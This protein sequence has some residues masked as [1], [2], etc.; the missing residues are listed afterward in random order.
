MSSLNLSKDLL[1]LKKKHKLKLLVAVTEDYDYQDFVSCNMA[2]QIASNS[3][4]ILKSI[5]DDAQYERRA[6]HI[7]KLASVKEAKKQNYLG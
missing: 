3:L 5:L 2:V 1:E 4:G 7:G 6:E